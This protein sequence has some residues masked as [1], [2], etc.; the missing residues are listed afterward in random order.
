MV[1]RHDG[2]EERLERLLDTTDLADALESDRF[3]QFL[4]HIPIAIAVSELQP[5][6]CI[7]YVNIEFERLTGKVG[8]EIE[9]KSWNVLA[10][11]ATA[12]DDE[13]HL[14]EAIADEQEYIGVFCVEHVGGTVNVDA[15]SNIIEDDDGAPVFRLLPSPTPKGARPPIKRSS[16]DVS[17]TKIRSCASCST[18]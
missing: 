14:S 12:I 18:G 3:K 16:R 1:T 5:S 2:N 11:Q 4:D 9:G 13:R 6:E 8:A 10:G 15:W 7:V 17:A